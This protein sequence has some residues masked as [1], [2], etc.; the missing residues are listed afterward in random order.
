[1]WEAVQKEPHE[2]RVILGT[3]ALRKV[4][5]VENISFGITDFCR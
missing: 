5:L 1:M 3:V 2:Q 4:G